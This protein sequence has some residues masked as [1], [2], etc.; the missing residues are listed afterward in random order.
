DGR[1][2]ASTGPHN[3]ICLWELGTGRE[4]QRLEGHTGR[5]LSLSFSS[6]SKRVISGSDDTSVLVW[7]LSGLASQHAP[8]RLSSK[9]L[10]ALWSD[11]GNDA[12]RAYQAMLKLTA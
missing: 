3:T 4:R 2:L 1:T 11:L 5:V 10:D 7:D 8:L 6:D 9:E 12:S